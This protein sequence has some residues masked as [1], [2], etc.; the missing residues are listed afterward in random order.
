M[1]IIISLVSIISCSSTKKDQEN[2]VITEE[3]PTEEALEIATQQ[4]RG[5]IKNALRL[6]THRKDHKIAKIFL[7]KKLSTKDEKFSFNEKANAINLLQNFN[8]QANESIAL[9]DTLMESLNPKQRELAWGVATAFPSKELS[10]HIEKHLSNAII[11]NDLE[12]ELVPAMADAIYQNNLISSYSLLKQGL[13]KKNNIAFAQAMIKL[14]PDKA[15]KDF[16]DY[17]STIPLEELRQLNLQSSNLFLCLDI[18][19]FILKRN[20]APTHSKYKHIFYFAISRN[21]SLSNYA[22]KIIEKS[23]PQYRNYLAQILTET[24][25]WIQLA[26]IEKTRR[27]ASIQTKLFFKELINLSSRTIV[28][29]EIKEVLR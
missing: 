19:T 28:I 17:L 21:Q 7:I 8:L 14:D 20:P 12:R 11:Y 26:Y 9:F 24:P 16:F 18:L 15:E 1:I 29:K 27:N 3:T 5:Q 23:N 6:I 10:S 2:P 13:F 22:I 25:T 4:G